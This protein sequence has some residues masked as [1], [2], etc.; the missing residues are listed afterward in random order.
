MWTEITEIPQTVQTPND[1]IRDHLQLFHTGDK[2]IDSETNSPS[3]TK[4]NVLNKTYTKN[5]SPAMF[6]PS[7]LPSVLSFPKQISSVCQDKGVAGTWLPS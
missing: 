6:S 4:L 3:Q 5:A 2:H 7:S 1:T